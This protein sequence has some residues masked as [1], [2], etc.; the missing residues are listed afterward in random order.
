MTTLR[1]VRGEFG[2]ILYFAGLELREREVLAIEITGQVE[3]LLSR[4]TSTSGAGPTGFVDLAKTTAAHKLGQPYHESEPD[5]THGRY[6]SR[7]N[8]TG[9]RAAINT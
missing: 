7:P 5:W 3:G 9:C 2:Q 1:A 6:Q 8:S 4:S